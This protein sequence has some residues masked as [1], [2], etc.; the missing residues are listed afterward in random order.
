MNMKFKKAYRDLSANTRKTLL[1]VFA[2]ALGVW[3]VGTVLVSYSVLSKD[4]YA[5]YQ[6]TSP[7]HA[8]LHSEDFGKTTLQEIENKFDVENA[9]FRDFSL[10]RIE[11][12]PDVWLPLWLFG[13]SNFENFRMAEV[14]HEEG[15]KIPEKGTI[16][17]ERDSRKIA[18]INTGS[19]VRINTG[20][21]IESVRISG[22]TFDPALAPAKQ[23]LF[24]YA[25]T[26]Q[27]TFHEIT[28]TLPNTRLIVRF[29]D[30]HSIEDV[31]PK[32]EK[33]S[34]ELKASGISVSEVEIPVFNEHPH[35]WQLNTLLFFIGSI[36]LL[37]FLMGA[38]LVSQLMKSILARQVRQVGIM[39]SIGASRRMVF[40]I[41]ISMLLLIGF[42]AGLIAIPLAII[43]G[44][45]FCG[46]VADQL[47]FNILTTTI[48]AWVYVVL[49][50]FSLLSPVIFSLTT[51][52]KGTR[53]SV[54]EAL[55]DYGVSNNNISGKNLS[56]NHIK[57]SG[58]TLLAI[59][60]SGRNMKRLTVTIFSMALGVAIFSTGF[61]V[62]Q[63][64]WNLLT[65]TEDE[66]RY[67]IQVALKQ[68]VSANEVIP[69]FTDIPNLQQ[70]ES[71]V[72]GQIEGKI[73]MTATDKGAVVVATPYETPLLHLNMVKGCPTSAD[74]LEVVLN[75][76][77][78]VL[79]GQPA[80]GS[81]ID[82]T[83]GKQ[84]A[85][86]VLSG[87]AKQYEKPRVF[88]NID[89]YNN[90]FNQRALINT[91]VFTTKDNEYGNVLQMKKN[92][93]KIVATSGLDVI[94]VMSQ[95]ERVKIIYDHL[96]IILSTIVML[97]FLVLVVS[98]IGMASA[99]GINIMERTREI[100]IMRTIG[101]TPKKIYKL[102]VSEGTIVCVLSILIG[103]TLAYPV[104]RAA[105]LFFGRLMLGEEAT[106]EFAFSHLGFVI[107]LLITFLFG[108]L[109][110]KIPAKSA[111][112]VS[113]YKALQYE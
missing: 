113:T 103:L 75:N 86:A 105:S 33:L 74:Q 63:S 53:I 58:L 45:G 5:N 96:N 83:I 46:F 25:Y 69:L 20:D 22:I 82:I 12:E 71:W 24:I 84:Q 70:I 112:K 4:L 88:F 109:A 110:S 34:S 57:L 85:N 95:A 80:V 65:S 9:E 94:Y 27:Q 90:Y 72:G 64:L 78:W 31:R 81:E 51:L 44:Q 47:N 104:S 62:R 108:W 40:Q 76:S 92:I 50:L 21:S 29:N 61:N 23:D 26:D 102:F 52:L 55:N 60:N 79:Y 17:I 77:A 28:G 67:D 1:V 36:G 39:K 13:V 66:L 100:G 10:N 37:A 43:S 48:P 8:V 59:R 42:V 18:D 19:T 106:L 14:F 41:Y 30:V 56:F 97:S 7:L 54:K 35:Q 16:L 38:V 3:G 73:K 89:Q 93:E 98:A 101:A 15:D 68:P 87:I 99:T 11:V 111:I 32:T 107:T 2:L 91:L 49:V 6:S